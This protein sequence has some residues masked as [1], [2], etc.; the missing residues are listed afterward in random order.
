MNALDPSAVPVSPRTVPPAPATGQLAR[1]AL[2]PSLLRKAAGNAVVLA[3]L[4]AQRSIAY[5]PRTRIEALRDARIARMVRYA[6]DT[7]PFYRDTFR[8]RGLDPRSFVTARDL[9]RLPLID[10]DEVR[11]DP[12]RFR[13]TSRSGRSATFFISSGSSGKPARIYHDRRSLLANIAWGERERRVIASILG[14]ELRYREASVGYPEGTIRRV[15]AF[16]QEATLLKRPARLD[17]SVLA[18]FAETVK[19]LN[20]F[21]PDVIAG[22]GNYLAAMSRAVARGEVKLVPPKLFVYSA[23]GLSREMR[24]EIED[25][26]GAPVLSHYSAVETFK[27]GFLCEARTGFHVHEDLCDVRIVDG[28]GRELADGVPGQIVISNLVNRGTV[29]LNYRLGD[30]GSFATGSCACGRTLRSLAEVDGR[31]EDML[32]VPDGRVL[33]PRAIWGVLKPRAEVLQYQLVQEQPHAFVLRLVTASDDD[34][35]RVAPVVA[36][37]IEALLGAGTRVTIERHV[38]LVAERSG[39]LR[40]VIGL[41]PARMS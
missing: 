2:V 15:R 19:Q 29:L 3:H 24:R 37:E 21:R 35:Q 18:P 26:L 1:A 28:E 23:E 10:K 30:L 33:H 12:E 20:A 13:S 38:K 31:V 39:K 22:F 16:Y 9:A 34:H 7:V 8:E 11:R 5:A 4:P 41:Q 14:R 32:E 36:R 25:T 17:L 40:M 27:L 6:A